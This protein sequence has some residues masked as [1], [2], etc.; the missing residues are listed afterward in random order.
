MRAASSNLVSWYSGL[1]ALSGSEA[2][3]RTAPLNHRPGIAHKYQNRA[4]VLLAV[5]LCAILAA[6]QNSGS[7]WTGLYLPVQWRL[8]RAALLGVF[9]CAQYRLRVT[10]QLVYEPT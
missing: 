9:Q 8:W 7:R 5:F 10:V 1:L 2:V 3:T 6:R 4:P